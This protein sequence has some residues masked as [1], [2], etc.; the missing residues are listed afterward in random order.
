LDPTT[1]TLIA[2]VGA[3]VNLD[4]SIT[5]PGEGTWSVDPVTGAVTFDPAPA[6]AGAAS[7]GYTIDDNDGNTSNVATITI[8]VTPAGSDDTQTTNT[9]TPVT[10]NVLS[11]DPSG[12]SLDLTAVSDPPH[13]TVTIAGAATGTVTYTPDAGF[14]GVDSYTYT[15]CVPG[16]VPALCTTQTVTV[17]VSPTGANDTAVTGLNTP[18]VVPVLAN[19]PSAPGVTVSET[20]DPPHGTLVVNSDGTVTYTPD[21][22]FSG[23]DTFTYTA[24]VIPANLP[25]A[26]TLNR[27]ILIDGVTALQYCYTQTVTVT[28]NPAGVDDVATTPTNTPVVI[29][30]L[31]ND[32]TI[33]LTVT[34]VTDPP[35]GRVV[36]NPDGT[37]TY[38]PDTGFSGTDTFTYTACDA[39]NQCVTRSVTVAVT[40]IGADDTASTPAGTAVSIPVLT[41]DPSG[42]SLTVRSA[43]T[44][45]HGTVSILGG[46]IVYTPAPGFSGTDTFSYTACDAANRCITQNVSVSVKPTAT[47]DAVFV[48]P[49]KPVVISVLKNDPAA[50]SVTVVAVSTP[51]HGTAVINADGTITYTPDPGFT[52]VDSFTYTVCDKA[53]QCVT[54][55]VR[56]TVAR[57]PATGSDTAVGLSLATLLVG[58]GA[59]L[60]VGGR[61]RRRPSIA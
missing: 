5:V 59:L 22:G 42:P 26:P 12:P 15:A 34:L 57:I 1:V 44:P 16:A 10:T 33:G 29:P 2:P 8:T 38:T 3:I 18:V 14:A 36:I 49:G 4:G 11:N 60:V 35:H 52:G 46:T 47:D 54:Q 20:S 37:V 6:F 30:V 32:G 31:A 19:D 58:A 13:G 55:T 53:N 24:C 9:N 7:I 50:P 21:A 45:A 41:N 28:V 48:E 27:Q 61:R 17:T 56:V 51:G 23:T 39:A 25:A 43:T 40:P